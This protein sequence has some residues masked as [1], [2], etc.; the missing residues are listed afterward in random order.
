M[1]DYHKTFL[2]HCLLK[3]DETMKLSSA[4]VLKLGELASSEPGFYG[5]YASPVHFTSA[6]PQGMSTHSHFAGASVRFEEPITSVTPGNVSIKVEETTT[7]FSASATSTGVG[8]TI[9]P[10]AEVT[11]NGT[12]TTV[13][14][15]LAHAAGIEAAAPNTSHDVTNSI[16]SSLTTIAHADIQG[17]E[18]PI[19]P[20]VIYA[21][22]TSVEAPTTTFIDAEPKGI[23]ASITAY[24]APN[25]LESSITIIAQADIKGE[26][27]VTPNV[28]HAEASNIDAPVNLVNSISNIND[29]STSDGDDDDFDFFS[30]PYDRE[31]NRSI[32]DDPP[33]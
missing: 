4:Y 27:P 20:T 22:T 25:S 19:T 17:I 29:N 14:A 30:M 3:V 8:S 9:T 1:E 11:Q 32:Y 15:N 5:P 31:A 24:A 10:I 16:E 33:R 21:E 6:C 2:E 13:A 7:S 26:V 28:A 12:E 18:T 23:E